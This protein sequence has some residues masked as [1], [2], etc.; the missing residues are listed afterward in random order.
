[1]CKPKWCHITIALTFLL[2]MTWQNHSLSLHVAFR[3][4][5]SR[6]V[7]GFGI[8]ESKE[9]VSNPGCELPDLW[10]KFGAAICLGAAPFAVLAADG[11]YFGAERICGCSWKEG[12]L[13]VGDC[14][15]SLW[16][17]KL[18]QFRSSGDKEKNA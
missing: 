12:S 11:G 7:R 8:E 15:L 16:R 3:A 13:V 9:R 6:S 14:A 17:K 5:R 1:M 10:R 18:R 4:P 2:A